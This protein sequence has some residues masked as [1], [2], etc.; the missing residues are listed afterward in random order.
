MRPRAGGVLSSWSSAAA[1]R[2]PQWLF[3]TEEGSALQLRG[4]W[5]YNFARGSVW[6]F[7]WLCKLVSDGYQCVFLQGEVW[8]SQLSFWGGVHLVLFPQ[9]FLCT[10]VKKGQ[11]SYNLSCFLMPIALKLLRQ[12]FSCS[13][14]FP[15]ASRNISDSL[16]ANCSCMN[17]SSQPD[18]LSPSFPVQIASPGPS[19]YRA[20][21]GGKEISGLQNPAVTR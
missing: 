20:H 1:G 2:C 19:K 7:P 9:F 4:G 17:T 6:S 12:L 5:V 10:N 3:L 11:K 18:F 14:E 16:N 15:Q 13:A 21:P 8:F